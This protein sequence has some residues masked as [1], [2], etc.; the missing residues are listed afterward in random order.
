M[1]SLETEILNDIVSAL[2]N[3]G[4]FAAVALG[5]SRGESTVPRAAVL[6][7][8]R[9]TIEPDDDQA[10]RWNR[11][12]ARVVIRTRSESPAEA[13]GRIADL[14]AQA[15]AAILADPYRSGRCHDLPIGRATEVRLAEAARDERYPQRKT[16]LAVNSPEAEL[17]LTVRCHY[18]PTD[19]AY[20]SGSLGGESLFSSGPGEVTPGP[21]LRE[22]IRRGFAGLDGELA[23]DLGRRSRSIE[24]TGR[25][26]AEDVPSLQ[27]IIDAID[28]KADGLSYTLI[29]GLG[30][31]FDR[32]IIEK[33]SLKTPVRKGRGY[34]CDYSITYRQLP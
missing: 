14:A 21:W 9:E 23:M 4:S 29:D 30:R 3:C 33:F 2:R 12:Q 5:G 15:T 26:Q 10:V 19:G 20:S 1:A 6:L 31:T 7:E 11:L 13:T 32:V 25:L 16:S 17:V 24:Q 18:Q 28:A 22:T 8:K 34:W 27:A